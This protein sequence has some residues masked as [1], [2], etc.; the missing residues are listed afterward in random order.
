MGT[1]RDQLPKLFLLHAFLFPSLET[2][3]AIY[4]AKEV[5]Y[6][7]SRY[8]SR[9]YVEYDRNPA[10]KFSASAAVYPSMSVVIYVHGG[11]LGRISGRVLLLGL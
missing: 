4:A 3:Q 6:I 10:R 5:F 7:I 8:L 2:S 9:E 11:F 1:L